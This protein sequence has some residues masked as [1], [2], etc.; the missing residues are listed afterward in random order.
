[1]LASRPKKLKMS[2][3]ILTNCELFYGANMK[4]TR[5]RDQKYISAI[6]SI[7]TDLGNFAVDRNLNLAVDVFYNVN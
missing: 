1:M 2:H 7:Y 3:T 6:L 5:V 4:C